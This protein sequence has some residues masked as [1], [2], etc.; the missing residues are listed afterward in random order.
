MKERIIYC[1]NTGTGSETGPDTER[2]QGSR[3]EKEE[4]KSLY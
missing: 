1:F 2:G 3:E 4:N